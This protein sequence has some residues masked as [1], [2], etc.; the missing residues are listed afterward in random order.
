MFN[1]TIE[2][3]YLFKCVSVSFNDR[4]K[5]RQVFGAA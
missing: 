4:K 5:A 3:L 1:Y 2:L